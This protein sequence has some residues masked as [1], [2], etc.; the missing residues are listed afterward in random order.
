MS[1]TPPPPAGGDP[2]RSRR[3]PR[4]TRSGQPAARA[5]AVRAAD[6]DPPA[7]PYGQPPTRR[8]PTARRSP[9]YGPIA[10]DHPQATTVLDPR[11]PR[12]RGVRRR[13]PPFAWVMGN[14]VIREIDAS[15][16]AARRPL[17]RQRRPHPAGSWCTRPDRPRPWSS[18]SLGV[19]VYLATA[20]P[21]PDH[22]ASHP[23]RPPAPALHRGRA[24]D[25]GGAVVL[26]AR[27]PVH[28]D[29][30]PGLGGAPRALG[31]PRRGGRRPGLPAVRLV[32]AGGAADRGDRLGHRR[33]DRGARGRAAR[34]RRP[35]PRGLA[36]R[37]RGHALAAR[38]GRRGQRP[39]LQRRRGLGARAPRRA[40]RP[41]RAVD[42]LPRPVAQDPA[43]QAA[44]GRPGLRRR[45][46]RAGWRPGPRGGWPPTGRTTPSRCARS[47]TRSRCSTGDRCPGG[48]TGR[49]P[50]SSARASRPAGRSPT[51]P[52]C[53]ARPSGGVVDRQAER[54]Q[55]QL[56]PA[57]L[58]VELGAGLEHGEQVRLAQRLA[59]LGRARG[60]RPSGAPRP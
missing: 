3:R 11:D 29:P 33:G 44:P 5:A 46:R 60:R 45:S 18:G 38:R 40:G 52:T 50:G 35:G 41:G 58:P 2:D 37:C 7:A 51:S 55:H 39:A 10:P 31:D 6:T 57:P 27:Q 24:P 8:C 15:G 4:R 43:P 49:S 59:A 16:G 30:G 23:A 17:Q 53:A 12:H 9:A 19:V 28:A 36:A 1:E 14:R 26:A 42:V 54:V 56:D 25:A 34:P 32:R 48:T 22:G 20:P 47:W 21:Q 13:S